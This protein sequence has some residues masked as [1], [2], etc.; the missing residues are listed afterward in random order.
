MLTAHPGDAFLQRH[1]D[2]CVGWCERIVCRSFHG[3]AANPAGET[4]IDA[5][6]TARY[7][8]IPFHVGRPGRMRR[9]VSPFN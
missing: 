6:T 3:I 9:Q 2:S 4:T 8:V 5:N 7:T 1:D